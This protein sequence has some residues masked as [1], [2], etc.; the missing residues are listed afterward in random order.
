MENKSKQIIRNENFKN[1]IF[2]SKILP[3]FKKE[4]NES[5]SQKKLISKENKNN[6]KI[7]IIQQNNNNEKVL[8]TIKIRNPGIDLVRLLAMY[9]TII[10]HLLVQGNGF[11]KYFH[12]KKYLEILVIIISWHNNGFALI[13]GIVGYKSHKYSNLLYL[14]LYELFYTIG[15]HIFFQKFWHNSLIRVS[16]SN[17]FFPIIYK[18]Y[19]YFTQYFGMYLFL[20]VI[21]K[22]I[23]ILTKSELKLVVISLIG[24]FSF[25]RYFKNPQKDIFYLQGG[26]SVLWFLTFFITGAYIGKYRIDYSGIKKFIYCIICLSIFSFSSD[27]YYKSSNNK[28]YIGNGYYIKKIVMLLNL[29]ITKHFDSLIK[30]MQ[31]ISITLFFLQIKYNIYLSKIISFF[32]PLAFGIHLIHINSIVSDNI[33]SKIF[34]NN[35]RNLTLYSTIIL[36]LFKSLKIEFICLFIDYLR[37]LLFSLLRIRKICIFLEKIA[38]KIFG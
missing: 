28:L 25:W 11:K 10:H 17:E 18:R 19:W 26:S 1:Y 12:F 27:L 38:F 24:I 7:D 14:W 22:G 23:S 8:K 37:F 16:I 6:I 30:I 5:K 20:P 9:C 2:N 34:N 36:I 32:G 13:S 21:N 4:K 3:Y 35:S 29:I 31:S 33:L 15:I